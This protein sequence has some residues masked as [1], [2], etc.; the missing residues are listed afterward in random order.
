[1]K[2]ATEWDTNGSMA[3]AKKFHSQEGMVDI[4]KSNKATSKEIQK[5]CNIVWDSSIFGVDTPRYFDIFDTVPIDTATLHGERNERK[6]KHVM[7]GNKLLNSLLSAFEIEITGSK[8]NYQC[9]QENDGLL[10]WDFI[11]CRINP[12]T[13]VGASKLKHE[14]EKMKAPAFD[15]DIIRYN[16]W[17]EDTRERIIKE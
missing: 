9:G 16:T 3:A 15:N 1:M 5:H 6:L 17:F 12:T 7:M 8:E 10:L 11:R 14:I 4:F 2:V 13:A